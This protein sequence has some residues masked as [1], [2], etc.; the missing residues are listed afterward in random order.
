MAATCPEIKLEMQPRAR[1]DVVDVRERVREKCGPML[2][3]FPWVLYCSYHT[4][5]GYLDQG[6]ASRLN[7]R[8]AGVTPYLRAFQ[9]VFPE[10]AGYQH[11]ELN[12]RE[13]LSEEQRRTEP[14]NGDSHLAFIG[15]GLR[16]CVAYHKRPNEPVYFIDFDGVNGT[17]PRQ[18]ITSV[19]GF[20]EERIV[21]RE[22]FRI[23]VAAQPV[24]AVNLKDPGFG[25]FD[26]IQSLIDR[27]GVRKGR[28]QLTLAETDRR[29]GLTVNEYET[30]LMQHDLRNVICDPFRFMVKQPCRLLTSLRRIRTRTMTCTRFLRLQRS[31]SLLVSECAIT[32]VS[33]VVHGKYQSPILVQ[34]GLAGRDTRELDFSLT[35]F[36]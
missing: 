32:G 11:D 2:E 18:R 27:H 30:L 12:L 9:T 22:R 15:A 7:A 14:R 36:Q 35:Q 20:T 5:A 34:W 3:R 29:A 28:V 19:V 8:R 16:S 4:T 21:V 31:I 26:R 6:L 23:P 13:E 17:C 1:F 25:L 10:G 24:D 33:R